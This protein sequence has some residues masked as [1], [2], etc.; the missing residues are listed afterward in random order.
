MFE[1]AGDGAAAGVTGAV[2]LGAT[3]TVLVLIYHAIATVT[4]ER[5]FKL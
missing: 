2:G 5:G 4:G 3:I 1:L